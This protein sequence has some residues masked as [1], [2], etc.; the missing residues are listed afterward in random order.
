MSDALKPCPF[1]N[2]VTSPIIWESIELNYTNWV[3]CVYCGG[4]GARHGY[5]GTLEECIA[6]WNTRAPQPPQWIACADREPEHDGRYA[7]LYGDK[8]G[9]R[10]LRQFTGDFLVNY[11]WGSVV[12]GQQVYFW[13]EIPPPPGDKP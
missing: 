12:D 2:S 10:H 6:A 1:C 13:M 7:I 9:K 5:R 3:F 4:C 8:D 11:G